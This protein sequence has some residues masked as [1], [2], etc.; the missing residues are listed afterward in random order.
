[1]RSYTRGRMYRRLRDALAAWT[2][3]IPRRELQLLAGAMLASFVVVLVYIL[4]TRPHGLTGDEIEYDSEGKFFTQG[5]LWWSTTPFGIAHAS[6]WKAPGYP[7]WVGFWYW[8]LGTVPFR[9]ELVQS[10]LAPLTV[11]G[12]WLLGRRLF[13]PRVAIVSAWALAFFPLAFEYYGLLFPEALAVPLTLA[14]LLAAFGR[15]PTPR[16]ALTVG[17]LVGLNLLVRPNSF[18]LLVAVAAAWIVAAGWRRGIAFTAVATVIAALVVLPW[19]IRNTIV[20]DG[21]FI[22]ISVQDG[23][24]YGTFNAESANDPDYP[25]AWRA[26]PAGV[27]RIINPNHPISDA[28]FRSRLQTAAF[29]Y[30]KGHPLSVPQAFF[31]NGIVRLWD[32]RPPNQ[33][34]LEA[35][36]QGRSPTL[37][38]IGLG[39]YYV[40]LPLALFGLWQSRR[41]R[42]VVVPVLALFVAASVTFTVIAGTR[43]RAPIEPLLVVLAAAALVGRAPIPASRGSLAPATDR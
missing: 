24:L 43:Y 30:I 31:W 40:I 19:T 41:R 37:R 1:M 36:V 27:N 39:M 10:L 25:Y 32:L 42:G 21:G 26:T 17:L 38:A 23:A 8:L 12:T 35:N 5:K 22:P 7:A 14:V 2:V 29:D 16:L 18:F 20:N 13:D 28:E 34:L 3:D 15:V 4:V 33:A 6:A 9:V 11:F